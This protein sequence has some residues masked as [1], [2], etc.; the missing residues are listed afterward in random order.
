MSSL[1]NGACNIRLINNAAQFKGLRSLTNIQLMETNLLI[2]L[3]VLNPVLT[4][5]ASG[6]SSSSS[7]LKLFGT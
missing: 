7:S 3:K 2:V 5:I 4:A 1:C 6:S